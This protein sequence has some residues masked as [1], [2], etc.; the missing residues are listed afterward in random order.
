MHHLDM[1]FMIAL[2]I[3]LIANVWILWRVENTLA[4]AV[5]TTA[6]IVA[7][8]AVSTTTA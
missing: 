8:P 1:I 7:A 6:A 3:I 4:P 5:T 2:A